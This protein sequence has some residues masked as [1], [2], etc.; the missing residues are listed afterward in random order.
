M[1]PFAVSLILLRRSVHSQSAAIG[2]MARDA[3]ETESGSDSCWDD[4]KRFAMIR[5]LANGAHHPPVLT[6]AGRSRS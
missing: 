1:T 6:G 3:I 4:V 2:R 5:L